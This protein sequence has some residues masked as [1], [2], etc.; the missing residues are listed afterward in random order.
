MDGAVRF[1]TLGDGPTGFSQTGV[2]S[3]RRLRTSISLEWATLAKLRPS[4]LTHANTK[5]SIWYLH[6]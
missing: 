2:S 4:H 6:V 1:F 5:L 3:V